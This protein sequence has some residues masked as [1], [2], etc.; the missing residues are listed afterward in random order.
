M[1]NADDIMKNA[2]MTSEQ[3]NWGNGWMDM[4][5]NEDD[6]TAM[7]ENIMWV[8]TGYFLFPWLFRQHHPSHYRSE[9]G[10]DARRTSWYEDIQSTS[11]Y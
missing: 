9:P 7:I 5:K 6:L 1:K 3:L 2:N 4:S 11:Y 10:M 8:V